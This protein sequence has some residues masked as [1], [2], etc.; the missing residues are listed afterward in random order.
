MPCSYGPYGYT[1][2]NHGTYGYNGYDRYGT[3]KAENGSEKAENGSKEAES[4]AEQ[5]EFHPIWSEMNML[6][7]VK[8]WITPDGTEY[9]NSRAELWKS[10]NAFGLRLIQKAEESKRR[11][12]GLYQHKPAQSS[13]ATSSGTTSSG[14]KPAVGGNKLQP[15]PEEVLYQIQPG[16][17]APPA[18]HTPATTLGQWQI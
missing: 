13:G 14:F 1:S 6:N 17:S 12:Q 18:S 11:Q 3:E 4:A 5:L 9:G 2:M 10:M 8:R 7:D 16:C 15:V